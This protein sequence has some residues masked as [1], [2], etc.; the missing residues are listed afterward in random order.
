MCLIITA[1]TAAA[2]TVAFFMNKKNGRDNKSVFMA[3]L[4]FWA[5]SLM[6]SMDGVASVLEGEGFFDISLEDT[7]LGVIILA[8][9]LA[10]FMLHS[11]WQ[12]RKAA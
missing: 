8:S 4:M 1:C 7:I 12:K 3:M 9:G 6:W 2:F 5:A 11:L 10:V